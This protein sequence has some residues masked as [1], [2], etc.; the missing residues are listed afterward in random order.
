MRQNEMLLANLDALCNGF[1][2]RARVNVCLQQTR[3]SGGEV[4]AARQEIARIAALVRVEKRR[5]EKEENEK[6][7]P[8]ESF[9][10]AS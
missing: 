4:A 3:E 6:E 8:K 10:T 1:G 7:E 9:T 5:K 2:S